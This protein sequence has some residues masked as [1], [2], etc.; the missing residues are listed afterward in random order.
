MIANAAKNWGAQ[1]TPELEEHDLL[2][3]CSV[4]EERAG[5]YLK[6]A[7]HD[8][9]RT[10]LRSRI[11]ARGL[12]SFTEYCDLLKGI[13]KNDPE[14]QIFTNLLTTNKTDFFRE[15]KHFEFL[16]EKILPTWLKTSEK[17]FKVWSAASSTGEEPYTLAMVL[18][19]HLGKD[20]DFKILASDIDTEVLKTAQNA[21]Y[22]VSKK[23]ELPLE[24]QQSAIELGQDNARGWFRIKPQ[25]K[26]KVSFKQ[27]N[28]IEKSA[29][30]QNAFDLIL[31]RNVLI[32]FAQ[33]NVDFVQTK[34]FSTLKPGGHLFI[35]HSES[36]QGIKHQWKSVGP[37]IFK[38]VP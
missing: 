30:G 27:H 32:Y 16:V 22:A 12:E 21:V 17:T 2:Y 29:P 25:I 19:R 13:A 38:K 4:I 35:G 28:L 37:S 9:V 23:S 15:I 1:N 34:L 7:K 24:Y 6:P 5:I 14:W 3:F 8:L 11:S 31:C 33:E 36:L 26:E 20:R 10:R 18:Q